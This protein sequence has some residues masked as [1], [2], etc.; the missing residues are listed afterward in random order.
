MLFRDQRVALLAVIVGCWPSCG[1]SQQDVVA[2][3][4]IQVLGDRLDYSLANSPSPRLI[5]GKDHF[6][7]FEPQAV[8]DML[9]RVS[10]IAFS[11]DIGEFDAPQLRGLSSQY[12]QVLIDGQRVPGNSSDRT[13][14]LDRIPAELIERIELIRSPT[15]DMDSQGIGGTLNLV[16]KDSASLQGTDW[17]LGRLYYPDLD[18]TVKGTAAITHGFSSESW[19]SLVTVNVQERLNPKT[20]QESIFDDQGELV[21]TASADDFRDTID[22][23]LRGALTYSLGDLASLDFRMAYLDNKGDE[24]EFIEILDAES[25]PALSGIERR[26]TMQDRFEFGAR[27]THAP[28]DEMN[29]QLNFNGSQFDDNS[30]EQESVLDEGIELLELR[31]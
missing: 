12:T 23:A 25:Q 8:G 17:R 18:P 20:K 15:P 21:R 30:N 2:L 27:F 3:E 9:K 5:Y 14:L 26:K 28:S 31:Q 13:V 11:G 22:R 1:F 7:S 10:G 19:S 4:E 24:S 6:Q 29:L 16:L